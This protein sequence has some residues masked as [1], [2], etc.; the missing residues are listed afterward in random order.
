[1]KR[2]Q[3]V[4]G[5]CTQKAAAAQGEMTL[6]LCLIILLNCSNRAGSGNQELCT[7][8]Y[9]A[10]QYANVGHVSQGV[11]LLSLI[12]LQK[13]TGK[14]LLTPGWLVQH[15]RS[16]AQSTSSANL[17]LSHKSLPKNTIENS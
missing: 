17:S 10:A 7:A 3:G 12:H 6:S 13:I 5:V 2:R 4:S 9:S 15:L 16:L 8:W 11:D 1:M 14:G